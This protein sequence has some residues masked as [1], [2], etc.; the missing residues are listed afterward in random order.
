MGASAEDIALFGEEPPVPKKHAATPTGGASAEDLALF[1]DEPPVPT[2]PRQTGKRF[3]EPADDDLGTAST[4]PLNQGPDA[5]TM[6]RARAALQTPTQQLG[7]SFVDL[8]RQAVGA[9]DFAARA[10]V[11]PVNTFGG[12]KA[13]AV[14]REFMRG[15]N[16]NIPFANAGVEAL[17]GP[18][19]E[20]EEDA[21]LAPGAQAAGSVAGLPVGNMV[22]GIAAKG[23]E[24]AA[25]LVRRA[26]TSVI[27]SATRAR[28]DRIIEGAQELGNKT[29]GTKIEIGKEALRDVLHNDP[30]L[31]A[32]LD[33]SIKNP[34]ALQAHLATDLD[35]TGSKIGDAY[36]SADSVALGAPVSD[37][38]RSLRIAAA[39]FNN[40]ADKALKKLI[41]DQADGFVEQFGEKGRVP[42][43]K[44]WETRKALQDRGFSGS[45]INPSLTKQAQRDAA[46]AVQRVIDKRIDE[47]GSLAEGVRNTK[48]VQN[49]TP[50][51]DYAHSTKALESLPELNKRYSALTKLH[52]AAEQAAVAPPPRDH[53]LLGELLHH[54][55]AKGTGALVGSM[56]GHHV[57]GFPGA[58]VGGL[59][60]GKVGTIASQIP[61]AANRALAQI[62]QVVRAGQ[63]P[64]PA[65]VQ[66]AIA[67]GVSA[68][69][70]ENLTR[71]VQVAEPAAAF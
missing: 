29:V 71:R 58:A 53:G 16:A 66:Q 19:A 43:T 5:A 12:G 17:G 3:I 8:G 10:L 28:A 45:V 33:A 24:A 69:T 6:A 18:A 31:A 7:Q 42:L 57:A 32:T 26:A 49:S 20:S 34:K 50:F 35:S 22:G 55:K 54:G 63:L 11:H 38:R 62:A 2:L 51:Q 48:A 44:L 52:D 13:P 70:I 47:I 64:P 37:V 41:N 23:I 36:R 60:G 67:A 30:Q 1:A 27:D 21:K 14:G 39:R 40:P 15:V 68:S 4:A 61:A 9:N 56:I 46:T 59:I 25:P 65:L